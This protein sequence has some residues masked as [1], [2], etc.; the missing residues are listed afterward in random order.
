[1]NEFNNPFAIDRAEHLGDDLYKYY[2]NHPRFEGLLLRKS[3]IIQGGRG[4]GKTMFFLYR[5]FSNRLLEAREAGNIE[6]FI[7]ELSL[8]GVHFRA[9]SDFVTAFQHKEVENWKDLFALY[10]N[11]VIG[12][13]LCEVILS[14]N[15]ILKTNIDDSCLKT[16]SIVLDSQAEIKNY[17]DL[18]GFLNVRELELIRFINATSK[19]ER[20]ITATNGY[21]INQIAKSI[22]AHVELRDKSVHIYVDEYEN[23]L[24]YQQE[25][26]NTLIKHPDPAIVD[27]CM[28]KSG[29]KTNSTLAENENIS[30]PD[31]YNFFDFESIKEDEYEKI[32]VDICNKRLEK[33]WPNSVRNESFFGIKELLGDY[34]V[35]SE[36]DYLV[37]DKEKYLSSLCEEIKNELAG[38]DLKNDL[39]K[40][41]DILTNTDD[42]LLLYLNLVLIRR[43]NKSTKL[44]PQEF[45]NFLNNK[46]PKYREW[47]HNNKNAIVYLVAKENRKKKQYY[48]FSTFK[49]L[50]SGIVRYF[51]ELCENALREA[52]RNGFSLDTLRPL[53]ISEQTTAARYVSRYRLN[54][55]DTY[56]PYSTRLRRFVVL[57]GNI[58]NRLHLDPN[59]SEP[60]RNH[61]QTNYDDLDEEVKKFL[62]SAEL[63][64]V[65]QRREET[66]DKSSSIDTNEFEFHLNHIYAPYFEISVRR[67]RKLNIRSLDLKSLIFDNIDEAGRVANL[68]TKPSSSSM[69]KYGR[70]LKLEEYWKI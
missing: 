11:L 54:D 69:T 13:R 25:L 55:I 52:H 61:F 62:N 12:Q 45:E 48:G 26:I 18:K 27:I 38:S 66:K 22:L 35:E 63:W 10:F 56:T 39:K 65:F 15:S 24:E 70:Q 60:E 51:L 7:Q 53:K 67:Q 16:I 20:P 1:M 28:R 17:S 44:I 43:N 31:D 46:S 30:Y 34:S 50:S 64:S 47:I 40:S 19:Y 58:F 21:V 6:S 33:Y 14:L 23:L 41:Y 49:M 59:I 2:A 5:T 68:L 8:I 4:S 3:L 36:L 32:L 57:L 29:L 9:D 42:I 37:D